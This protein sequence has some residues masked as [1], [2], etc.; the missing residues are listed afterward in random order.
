MI[1]T[2]LIP[3]MIS[4]NT[5]YQQQRKRDEAIR[6]QRQQRELEEKAKPNYNGTSC[7]QVVNNTDGVYF[8]CFYPPLPSETPANI[9]TVCGVY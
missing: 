2:P 9:V 6:Q 3:V 1:T 7:V 8:C 4:L 5:V